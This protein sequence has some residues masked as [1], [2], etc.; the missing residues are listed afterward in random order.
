MTIQKVDVKDILRA[1]DERVQRQETL[2]KAHSLPLISFTLNIAGDIKRDEWIE[3]AFY[4]G[5]RR[6]EDQLKW[7]NAT[8]AGT[9][10]TLEFTGCEQIWAV[11]AD[12]RQLKTWMRA[13][14]EADELG[15]LFDIDV[16]CP[17]GAKLSRDSSR[18]CLICDSPVQLCARNRTHTASELYHRAIQIIRSALEHEKASRIAACAQ[19][20]LM[21]EA[22]VTPKPGLVDR[23]NSGSHRDMDIFSFAASAS[24]LGCYFEDCARAGM[25]AEDTHGLLERLRFLGRRAEDTMLRATGNINTHK[26]AIFSLGILCCAA[27]MKKADEDLL[28]LASEIAA[29]ALQELKTLS[30]ETA[31]T[32]GERQY[33]TMGLTGARGEAAGGFP[34]VSEIAL[35]VLEKALS[36]GASINDAGL[37]ALTAL[38]AQVSDSNILRRGGTEA[39]AYVSAAAQEAL[40][41]GADETTLRRLNDEF[42]RRNISPGGCADLLA[43]AYF[44]HLYLDQAI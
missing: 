44:L 3:Q 26:G 42:V 14:E 35:P 40:K 6:I 15:R 30:P 36:R 28:R 37:H 23:E 43:A 1:R 33:L 27:G 17:D 5:A 19:Q 4:E 22:L 8:C 34:S 11:Q 31:R 16:I 38:M 24:V 29:P 21:Y 25:R 7:H 12:A 10:R 32:G 18:R 9:V 2:L 13:I 20:A 41:N 39:Q